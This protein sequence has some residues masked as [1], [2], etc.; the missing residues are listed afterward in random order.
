M[1]CRFHLAKYLLVTLVALAAPRLWAQDGIEGAVSRTNVASLLTRTQ[2]SGQTLVAA[3]FDNDHKLDGAIL[4]A[5]GHVGDLNR[6]RIELHLSAS[7]NSELTFESTQTD[8]TVGAADVNKDGVEDVVVEQP[9]THKRL[10]VWLGDGRGGFHNVPAEDFPASD[11]A[12]GSR[13][14]LRSPQFDCPVV[15]L[16]PQRG[17]DTA[18]LTAQLHAGRPPSE[19]KTAAFAHG[20]SPSELDSPPKP[21][22]APPLSA[23][24]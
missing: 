10:Y 22:R 11:G 6:F 8:L 9:F 14:D 17:T 15:D 21:S 5:S 18:K 13:I 3:D 19:S 1:N 7:T 12:T 20:T 4:V 2:L 16:A 24:L 23:L